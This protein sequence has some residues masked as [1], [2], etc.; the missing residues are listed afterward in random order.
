[1]SYDDLKR[2]PG[3][4]MYSGMKVGGRHR[5]TYPDGS[6]EERKVTPDQWTFSFQSRKLRRNRAPAGSGAKVGT[7]YHW[8]ILAHQHV[9]KLDAN[10][11]E[12]V[13][14]GTKH[15]IA[16][17]KPEG[18]WSTSLKGKGTQR[19]KLIR[20]LEAVVE[21]LKRQEDAPDRD[22]VLRLP[23][24]AEPVFLPE[25]TDVPDPPVPAPKPAPRDGDGRKVGR[26]KR[27]RASAKR[28]SRKTPL[29]A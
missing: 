5:W 10:S 6:W 18:R 17:Q 24:M 7:K 4:R 29:E 2:A 21:D 1:M 20:I 26:A 9:Q 22:T 3:K 23:G 11:Y 27:S 19:Q 16:Y 28:A 25:R 8:F 13:M 15:L 14:Q 12:T